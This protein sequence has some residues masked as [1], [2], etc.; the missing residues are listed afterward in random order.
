MIM[1]ESSEQ[2]R[3]IPMNLSTDIGL[4][5][6]TQDN[7]LIKINH[8]MT[9]PELS[10]TKIE[11]LI[12]PSQLRANNMY[13]NEVPHSLNESQ[14]IIINEEVIIPMSD[15]CEKM[16][17][18]VKSPTMK[19][20]DN[21][22]MYDFTPDDKWE[23]SMEHIEE[24]DISNFN[25]PFLNNNE[26][27]LPLQRRIHLQTETFSVEKII[28][29][30]LSKVSLPNKIT[31]HPKQDETPILNSEH[32]NKFHQIIYT[33]IWLSKICKIDKTFLVV[34]LSKYN[35]MQHQGHLQGAICSFEYIKKYPY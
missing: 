19:E 23:P 13:V 31:C 16:I 5:E 10:P 6:S 17:F 2:F 28:R 12:V 27:A 14:C 34:T 7:I 32:M 18:K 15:I 24:F 1:G 30:N 3:S 21:L 4:V 26:D 11:F 22:Q 29:K 20:L 33:D 25:N 35:H 8:E 9:S